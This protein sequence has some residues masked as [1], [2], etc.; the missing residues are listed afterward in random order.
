MIADKIQNL[1]KYS[2]VHPRFPAAIAFLKEL[3]ATNPENGRYHCPTL[4]EGE[5]FVNVSSYES[6]PMEQAIMEVHHKYI[7]IQ[8]VFS[9]EEKIYMPALEE[10]TVTKEFNEAGDC[11]IFAM[12]D[13]ASCT[14][15]TLNEGDFAI[16]LPYE[17]HAPNLAARGS[18]PVRKAVVKVLY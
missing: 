6:R 18:V 15:A 13:P 8:V 9:G 16:F 14:C 17:I 1:E 3:L 12:A 7:D 2:A 4:P 11:A 5:V 10:P